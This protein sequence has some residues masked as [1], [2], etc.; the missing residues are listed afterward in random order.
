MPNMMTD[1]VIDRVDLVEEGCNSAAFIRLY[2]SRGEKMS[3][4][5]I[6][7]SLKRNSKRIFAL[8]RKRLEKRAVFSF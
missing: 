5:S 2:K 4:E 8:K 6:L 3:Y 1:L 7:K